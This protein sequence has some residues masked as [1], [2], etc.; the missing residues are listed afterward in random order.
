[1]TPAGDD[2]DRHRGAGLGRRALIGGALVAGGVGAGWTLQS[3]RP[4]PRVTTARRASV[5][6]NT[7]VEVVDTGD[8]QSLS[9]ARLLSAHLT[10]ALGFAI[11]VRGHGPAAAGGL[12]I[13]I[14]PPLRTES[15]LDSTLRGLGRDGFL[16]EVTTATVRIAGLDGW[17]TRFGVLDFLERAVGAFWLMPGSLG[18]VVPRHAR[19]ELVPEVWTDAPAFSSRAFSPLL[20]AGYDDTSSDSNA[21][22]QWGAFARLHAERAP[23]HNLHALLPSA[24]FGAP[25]SPD[26]TPEIYPIRGGSRKI[27]AA[28][29]AVGW[30]PRFSGGASVTAAARRVVEH[31]TEHEDAE[32]LSLAVNDNGGFSDDDLAG[33]NS[34]GVPSAS[35]AY[36]EWV[37]RVV[38][39][40][41]TLRPDLASKR[42]AVLAYGAVHDPPPFGLDDQVTVF[43]VGDR[44][45]WVKGSGAAK[46]ARELKAWRAVATNVAL[47]DYLYG[48]EYT[49]PRVHLAAT[50]RAYESAR[51]IGIRELYGELYPNWSEGPKAWAT[52]RL[53]WNPAQST[54]DLVRQW[55]D[56][57]VGQASGLHLSSYFEVWERV[58]T[59]EVPRTD[60]FAIGSAREFFLP[61]YADL[62]G[63]VA[64]DSVREARGHLER[65]VEACGEVGRRRLAPFER[66]LGLH[67]D[68]VLGFPRRDGPVLRG[69][70]LLTE[71][72]SDVEERV[73]T[74]ARRREAVRSMRGDSQG[75]ATITDARFG[76][77]WSGPVGR[78]FW[79]LVDWAAA[80]SG[81]VDR[82]TRLGS[83]TGSQLKRV[84]LDG[85][86]NGALGTLDLL[87]D[88]TGVSTWSRAGHVSIAAGKA[89]IMGPG[90]SSLRGNLSL[91]PGLVALRLTFRSSAKRSAARVAVRLDQLNPETLA[92]SA[93]IRQAQIS[94]RRT[95]GTTGTI[96]LAEVA[97]HTGG[98][99]EIVVAVTIQVSDLAEGDEVE[100][101]SLEL[102][103][104][105]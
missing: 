18:T 49:I 92:A 22:V 58:W 85:L 39:E 93:C 50:Q 76:A 46:D 80:G 19:L 98:H 25:S 57:L 91:P 55:C 77:T 102:T 35:V 40:V 12:R 26:Y 9:A 10:R 1:M 11:P 88:P 7:V 44:Y 82:I 68:S 59:R 61:N 83:Q 8:A 15:D 67:E 51:A 74:A 33:P 62:L 28:D 105:S 86:R 24:Q 99:S 21:M 42:Y 31:F 54:Q 23:S 43:V 71:A 5:D 97:L 45:A 78:D 63:G 32:R 72:L 27:P 2:P 104:G 36:Y 94:A 103:T 79:G 48:G 37:N 3:G 13:V 64:H 66:A 47:Y 90:T 16:V 34:L 75:Y 60:W 38:A 100:L 89:T 84:Y 20:R 52:S 17:G 87:G 30:Q 6:R 14:G 41:R 69:E 56:T 81:Q 29:T 95:P 65:A 70:K 4:T 53:L 101:R 96:E 73:A